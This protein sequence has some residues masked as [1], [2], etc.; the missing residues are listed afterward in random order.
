MLVG[1]APRLHTLILRDGSA[2]LLHAT[3]AALAAAPAAP[4]RRL[5][6]LLAPGGRRG[7]KQTCAEA[8]AALCDVLPP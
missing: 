7:N 4:L 2:P 5:D 8:L 1:T 6:V 3:A